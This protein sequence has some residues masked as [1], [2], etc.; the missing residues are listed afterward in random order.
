MIHLS[1]SLMRRYHD[2]P[3]ALL[4]SEKEH[5]LACARC[6]ARYEAIAANAGFAAAALVV[7]G[8]AL[9]MGE[10]RRAIVRRI[11][12]AQAAPPEPREARFAWLGAFLRPR[13]GI[14][15]ALAAIALIALTLT[16]TPARTVA[17]GFLAIFEPQH[18]APIAVTHADLATLEGL[19]DLAAFGTMQ[20]PSVQ[21]RIVAVHDALAAGRLARA[22][23]SE[24][25][26]LPP[27]LAPGA[28]ISVAE[29]RTA[30]FTFSAARARAW[31]TEHGVAVAPMPARLDGSTLVAT[32]GPVVVSMYGAGQGGMVSGDQR[33]AHRRLR[34][35]MRVAGLHGT[36]SGENV[37]VV[38]QAP[39][40]RI[41]STGASVA[42]IRDYLLAQPGISPNLVAQIRAIGDPATTL[43]VP[44]PIDRT[45]AQRV[46]VQ[47]VDGLALG[48]ETGLGSVVMWQ[49]GGLVH[50]VAA[51]L[52]ENVVLAVAN[53]MAP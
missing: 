40:P 42:E 30:S 46:V 28:S 7:P 11:A 27:Q 12:A 31:A 33:Y 36:R 24:P 25:R 43:P 19:P 16:F 10:A 47:G 45:L 2:E 5:L 22:Q 18:F 8:A 13:A 37:L 49:R 14:A 21:P 44:I 32:I 52:P 51:P 26:Y 53:S 1:A 35:R 4:V 29:A 9:D 41:Y 3:D 34:S 38:V 48:D 50:A 39:A 6:R 15:G 17:Q 23:V 20:E